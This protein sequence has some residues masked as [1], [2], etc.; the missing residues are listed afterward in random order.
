MARRCGSL[1]PVAITK[2]S[3]TEESF[4]TSRIAILSAFLLSANSRHRSASFRESIFRK[5]GQFLVK[6][7]VPIAGALAGGIHPR[8]VLSLWAGA[9]RLGSQPKAA[10]SLAALL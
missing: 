4:R 8:V 2:K 10:I 9:G 3:V 1:V 5:L 6:D 7:K